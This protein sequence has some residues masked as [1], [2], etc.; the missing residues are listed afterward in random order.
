MKTYVLISFFLFSVLIKAQ[1]PVESGRSCLYLNFEK[2]RLSEGLSFG[3]EHSFIENFGFGFKALVLQ[4][5]VQI[6]NS[7]EFISTRYIV[8]FEANYYLNKV[9]RVDESK[10]LFYSGLN[11]TLREGEL[12]NNIGLNFG[13]SRFL[14]DKLGLRLGGVLYLSHS[15]F[16]GG[17]VW[18]L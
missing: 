12:I 14:F 16:Y 3:F 9:F 7:T 13:S 10:Q 15:Q 17:I 1:F 18:R 6:N 2:A 8:D 4:Q 5:S 11:F